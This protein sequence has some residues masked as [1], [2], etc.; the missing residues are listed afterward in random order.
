MSN[1]NI[2]SCGKGHIF[3]FPYFDGFTVWGQ[4][5]PYRKVVGVQDSCEV[6]S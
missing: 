5:W 4:I 1:P 3:S 2:I 6:Q